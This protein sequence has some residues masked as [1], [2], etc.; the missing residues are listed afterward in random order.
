MR[1]FD[2]A[3][4]Y[5]FL[6][7][8][9]DGVMKHHY[10]GIECL[11][12][13][14]D[15]AIQGRAIWDLKPGTIIE[16]GSHKG[17]SALWM[18]DMIDNYGYD[19]GLYSIDITTPDLSDDRI[20]FVQGDVHDLGPAFDA[21]N[22]RNAPRP[23][24]VLEDSAH[25]YDAC[26]AALSFLATVMQKG[27]LLCMEDGLLVELGVGENYGGGPN[28]AI[29]EFYEANPGVFEVDEELCDTFGQNATYAPN[30]YM[31]KT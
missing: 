15:M 25:T 8:Y 24:F 14:I 2:S 9:Q 20:T 18:A 17:A 21:H 26:T 27:D 5:P 19:T 16:I 29:T 11:R 1:S 28:R 30:G 4:S 13:P 23:W 7:K 12:S 6:R 22:L 3:F 10:R 31:W